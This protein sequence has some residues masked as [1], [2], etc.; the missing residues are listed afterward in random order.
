MNDSYALFFY[1]YKEEIHRVSDQSYRIL[2]ND[3]EI[4]SVVSEYLE[5]KKMDSMEKE[6]DTWRVFCHERLGSC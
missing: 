1:L 4:Y 3:K 6:K 5:L 2:I